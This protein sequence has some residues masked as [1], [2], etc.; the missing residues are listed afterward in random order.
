MFASPAWGVAKAKDRVT[1]R[2]STEVFEHREGTACKPAPSNK[3][4][5]IPKS[6]MGFTTRLKYLVSC[7]VVV[8]PPICCTTEMCD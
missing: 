7:S 5:H 1:C 8:F 3:V 4:P 6:Y 2:S